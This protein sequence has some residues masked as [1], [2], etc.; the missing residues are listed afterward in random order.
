MHPYSNFPGHESR[1][2]MHLLFSNSLAKNRPLESGFFIA[3]NP[4]SSLVLHEN[5]TSGRSRFRVP[6][7]A[8][9]VNYFYD[10]FLPAR[11]MAGGSH[12]FQW[13]NTGL[14]QIVNPALSGKPLNLEP[15]NQLFD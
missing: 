1:Q 13:V 10:I 8:F 7:S 15:L 9:R 3:Y 5:W 11:R 14:T 6:G 4:F 12:L 2:D